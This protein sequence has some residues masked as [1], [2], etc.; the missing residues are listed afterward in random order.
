VSVAAE[1][2]SALTAE[3]P[4]EALRA[5]DADGELTRLL[6]GLEAGRGF[7]QPPLHHYTVLDHNLAAVEALDAATGA[8][9]AGDEL[10]EV[11][12]WIDFRASLDREIEGLPLMALLR[13][14]ALVHD[15][16]KPATAAIVDGALRFPRHGPRGA[17]MLRERLPELG[18]GEEATRFV[19]SMVRYHLRPGELVRQRPPTDRAIRKFVNDLDGHVLP[20]MLINV[21]D[22]W[23]TRGPGYTRENYRRHLGLL[24]YVVARC[25]A[26]LDEGDP[27]LITGEDLIQELDLESGRLLGAVLTS[28]R[29]AQSAGAVSTREEAMEL[30]GTLLASMQTNPR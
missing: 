29:R 24:N 15:I 25:W 18:F 11:L 4:V 6:P 13:L 8:G 23:A 9:A 30:A 26:V 5:L 20:L 17:E 3:V 7:V 16:A 28:V 1:L 19:A 2:L 27:P 10:R 21:A 12:G 14:A 22:G